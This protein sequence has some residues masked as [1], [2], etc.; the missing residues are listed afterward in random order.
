MNGNHP[1]IIY[2]EH[3]KPNV[4]SVDNIRTQI[5][6]DIAIKP[7]SGPHKIYIMDEAEKM[8]TQAQ[9]ALL[10]TLEEPPEYA[11]I[12]LLTTNVESM[13]PTILLSLIHILSIWKEYS[14]DLEHIGQYEEDV[15]EQIIDTIP[16]MQR[17]Y[18]K[19]PQNAYIGDF[20]E[21]TGQYELVKAYPGTYLRKGK[22]CDSIKLAL[23]NMDSELN[24]EEA[25]CYI[26]PSITSEDKELLRLWTEINK[27][28]DVYKRQK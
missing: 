15:L 26:E 4:I 12:L 28:V 20:Q 27:Q 6:G 22:V 18:M 5:N 24:L 16:F 19:A 7:Y 11:V 3:D 21:S 2:V 13:L 8:N 1:D 25:G 14:Y 9:N 17:D 10:K 23:E